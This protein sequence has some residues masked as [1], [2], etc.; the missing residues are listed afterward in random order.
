MGLLP[1]SQRDQ[2]RF[3]IAFVALAAPVALYMLRVSDHSE[4][5]AEKQLRI[6][7]LDVRNDTAKAIMAR[8]GNSAKVKA[9]TELYRADLE[10]LRVLV[11]VGNEVPALLEQVSNSARR[12]K[13][14]IGPVEPL[15]TV[16][17]EMF[18]E[19]RYKL[20]ITG[21][22]HDIAEALTHIASLPRIVAPVNV[23]LAIAPPSTQLKP[24][25]GKQN[26]VATFEIQTAVERTGTPRAKPKPP[27]P[28]AAAGK[29]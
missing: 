9:Q 11:P 27:K 17:G 22:Y 3:L 23:A 12:A 14:D 6:D 18:D 7:S 15:P 8:G 21:A 25:A 24:V 19:Y 5:Y 20:K 16:E 26:I 13:L 28:T 10:R 2:I 4:I 29:P 1:T